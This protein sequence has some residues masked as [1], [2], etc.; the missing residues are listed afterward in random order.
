TGPLQRVSA[1][2]GDAV[3]IARPDSAHGENALRFPQFLPDGRH[4]LFV[5]LPPHRGQMDTF[6]GEL[7][8]DKR[9]LL[10]TAATSPTFDGSHR[11]VFI[12]G[13]RLMAQEFD[14]GAARLSGQ[15]VAIGP[16]P[17]LSGAAGA[18]GVS[19]SSTGLMT[20]T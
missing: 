17:L 20:R 5:G 18:P 2:G 14:A 10:M 12:R 7:G 13:D 16:G 6:V 3:V 9:R 11:L 1:D 8:S 15:P 4:Y 19:L